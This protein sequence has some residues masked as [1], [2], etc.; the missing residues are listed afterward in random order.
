[1]QQHIQ[2]IKPWYCHFWP[3]FIIALLSVTIAACIATITLAIKIPDTPL[4]NQ[5]YKV[6]LAVYERADDGHSPVESVEN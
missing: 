5:Y 6:G 4:D 1:M 2:T 3:W